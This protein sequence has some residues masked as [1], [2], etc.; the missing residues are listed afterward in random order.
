RAQKTEDASVVVSATD[1]TAIRETE[2]LLR[3]RAAAVENANNGIGILDERGRITY[4][5]SA[6]ARFLGYA[7]DTDAIGRAWRP[8]YIIP[9]RFE[10]LRAEFGL[11]ENAE[12]LQLKS[13]DAHKTYHEMT[14][15]HVEKV[16][17]VLVARDVSAAV[18]NRS[19]L[20]ELNAQVEDAR[21]HEALSSLAAGLAHDFNNVL[22]AISG[23]AALISTDLDANG[24]VKSHAERI[25]KA[26]AMAARLVNR[27][28]DLSSADDDASIFDLRAVLGELRALAEVNLS[29]DTS[30]IM[31]SGDEA[32]QIRAA[33]SDISL[34]ILNLVLNA[35]DALDAGRGVIEL[36][37][38]R[39]ESQ[40]RR[41][42]LV[43]KTLPRRDYAS[44]TVCDTGIGIPDDVLPKIMNSFFTTK[45]HRGTGAGLA[46][47]AAIV[48]RL[49][50]AVFVEST[51]GEGTTI[52]IALPLIPERDDTD[53]ELASR[54]D[55]SG[56]SVM[57]LDDQLE[58]AET[59]AAFLS[60]CGAE[61]SVLDDP[62]LAVEVVL[63]ASQDWTAL[64]T[65]YD[66]PVMSGGDVI[67]AIH[68]DAPEF[69]LFLVT[70]LA[71]RISDTRINDATVRGVFA[72][73]V[74]LGQLA[75]ALA[76]VK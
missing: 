34:V 65:D 1:T 47:V 26:G 64:V 56:T 22:S 8:H 28:L 58:V 10:Q 70:A 51:L 43:G 30:F 61:V 71:R 54:V 52:E 13:G 73:P 7:K 19:R 69:P 75:R 44:I 32:L 29:G 2:R 21:R 40:S 15:T 38:D 39:F 35:R 57:V 36:R 72:K 9:E 31:T 41:T 23:S 55:L 24:E 66:M 27:M 14:V 5:N 59:T 18:R 16:D 12:I 3:Q 45:G 25:T 50:G 68:R 60:S 4:A 6:L 76:E 49:D 17:E 48:K 20:A 63:E 53:T 11:A 42:P 37:V 62:A 67:E 33:I 46:M 74:N